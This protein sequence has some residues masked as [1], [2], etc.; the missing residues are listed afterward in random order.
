MAKFTIILSIP[1]NILFFLGAREELANV[2]QRWCCATSHILICFILFVLG[3]FPFQGGS[4]LV[5]QR[6]HARPS[7]AG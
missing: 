4:K 1:V 6:A 5:W 7:S 3:H 2:L